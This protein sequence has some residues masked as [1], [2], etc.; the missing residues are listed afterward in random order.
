MKKKNLWYF[1]LLIPFF[2]GFTVAATE[3][4]T[5][6]ERAVFEFIHIDSKVVFWP[7]YIITQIGSAVGI[8]IIT[9]LILFVSFFKKKFFA[10]GLPVALTAV[11][12]RAINITLKSLI[13]RPR[14]EFKV[15]EVTESSFPSGHSQNNMALYIS[16]LLVALLFVNLPRRRVA[17]KIILISLPLIIGITRIYFGVHYLSD[18]VAGWSMGAFIAIFVHAVYFAIY[19]KVRNKNN[20]ETRV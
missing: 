7:M 6:L 3:C 20:A 12:S 9:A 11:I 14:P 4:L 5:N 18:V 1:A 16:V 8:I 17:L 13:D 15:I 19:E 10:V 2:G